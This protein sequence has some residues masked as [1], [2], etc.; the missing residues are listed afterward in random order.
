MQFY[1]IWKTTAAY[2][3]WKVKQ[4][5]R[6]FR[7]R[8]R[9]RLGNEHQEMDLHNEHCEICFTGGQLL[10][11]DGCERAYHFYCVTP[12]IDDVPKEDWFC[13]KCAALI[14]TQMLLRP[15]EENRHC[16]HVG[17]RESSKATLRQLNKDIVHA[18]ASK[19]RIPS[20]SR[21]PTAYFCG[22]P[23]SASGTVNGENDLRM[24]QRSLKTSTEGSVRSVGYSNKRQRRVCHPQRVLRAIE[25]S[26]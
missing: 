20:P 15:S 21:P 19:L 1:Y 8:I 24:L 5:V 11:C 25:S 17:L 10:C 23:T 13:P 6:R 3:C 4:K 2:K 12:P 16:N 14:Q 18:I 7:E 9:H 26:N 22:T